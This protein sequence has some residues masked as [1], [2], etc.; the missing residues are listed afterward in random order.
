MGTSGTAGI[1]EATQEAAGPS[2]AAPR[3]STSLLWALA[4]PLA[5]VV[6]AVLAQFP[7]QWFGIVIVVVA[8]FTAPIVAGA[9]WNRAGAATL[10]A[11]TTFALGLFAGPALV[12]AYV[13]QYGEKAD[14][15]VVDTAKYRNAGRNAERDVC[16]VLDTSGKVQDL[17]EQQNCHGQFEPGQHIVLYKDPLGILKPWADAADDRGFDA[18]SLGATGG[19]FTVT[20]ATL[21]YAGTRRRSGREMDA[22]KLRKYGPPR[23][24]EP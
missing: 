12:E 20:A 11:V 3:A 17:T 10:A 4:I 18:V 7:W 8:G 22:R 9:V 13:K 19:L 16:R 1:A 6:G 24:S 5:A 23:R 15:L 21:F 2:P 14:V